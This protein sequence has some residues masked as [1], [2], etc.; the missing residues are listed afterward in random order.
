VKTD[1]RWRGFTLI[2]LLVVIAIIAIL[3]AILFPVFAQARAAARKASC[4]SNVR[5]LG[6][7]LQMYV[8]DYDQMYPYWSWGERGTNGIS[9][10]WHVAIF[11]YVKNTGIYSCPSDVGG[12]GQQNTDLYW[13]GGNANAA[14]RTIHAPQFEN[15]KVVLSYGMSEMFHAGLW[16][17]TGTREAAIPA[18]ASTVIL[19]DSVSLLTDMWGQNNAANARIVMRM[20]CANG[21]A[22]GTQG[23]G[24]AVVWN[25]AW[26]RDTRHSGGLNVAYADG[27]VKFLKGDRMRENLTLPPQ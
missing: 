23:I 2:E 17:G 16:T 27:H 5:Q 21:Q 26:D 7:G 9:S 8:Q 15:P 3:A 4:A 24:D 6:V 25:P 1:R 11:P 20:A 22:S 12:W 14:F 10:L 19:G 18:P 13:W